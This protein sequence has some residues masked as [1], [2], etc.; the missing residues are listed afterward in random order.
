[1]VI[2]LN[3]ILFDTGT[4]KKSL[5]NCTDDEFNDFLQANGVGV[6]QTDG[7]WSKTQREMVLNLMVNT[8][9]ELAQL[10]NIEI[11]E[12]ENEDGIG[13]S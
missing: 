7:S 13:N 10:D 8:M 12:E 2:N 9:T 1:M 5:A 3:K 4:S 6:M 11:I